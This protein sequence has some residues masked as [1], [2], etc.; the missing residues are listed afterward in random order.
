M[1]LNYYMPSKILMGKEIIKK[2]ARNISSFGK[3]AFIITG[4]HSSKKNGSLQ[5][6]IEV[7]KEENIQY[8]IF[9]DIEENPSLETVEKAALI[10]RE[11]NIDF[12]IGVGGGSPIDA[13]KAIGVMIKN[14]NL[15]KDTLITNEK[16]QSI[17]IIAVP[18]TAGTG[19]EAT[20]YSILT[21]HK[22]KT[23]KNLGQNI[24]PDL[25][26]LD[27]TYTMNMNL[28]VT[29][30]TAID[31]LSHI[32]EGYLNNNASII[33]DGLAEKALNL[34]G[35]CIESLISGEFSYEDRENLMVASTMGGVIIAQ[36]GTSL[37]H[38]MGYPLTYFKNIPHGLANGC[39]YIQYL[40]SFKNREKVEKIYKLLG[41]S[42]YEEF[43]NILRKLTSVEIDVTKS[44][45]QEYAMAM[46]SN[47]AK[48]Q[49]HPETVGFEELYAIYEGSL[50][51]KM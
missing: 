10:G 4:K 1:E 35:E 23:K 50:I 25:S 31:A 30:N 11:E 43:E 33:S 38:G 51:N 26:L 9:D 15:T 48:L 6:I 28:K 8:C 27:P 17:S 5:D 16:L 32:I 20:Q 12:I 24:F 19:T 39:L 40:R 46:S 47:K 29:R 14:R 36:T 37:P 21:D 34:W 3:K 7:L 18:T 49:N 45:L 22:D 13:C 44:E 41:L 42:S 2:S